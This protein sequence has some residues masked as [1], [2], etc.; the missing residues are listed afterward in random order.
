MNASPR[1]TGK[2]DAQLLWVAIV[3]IALVTLLVDAV[4]WF[5]PRWP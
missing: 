2:H 5:E 1:K 3:A 4:G